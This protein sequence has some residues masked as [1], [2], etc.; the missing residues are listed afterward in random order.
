M[1]QP[2]ASA[3]RIGPF[4]F[5]PGW[6]RLNAAT[7]WAASLFTIGTVAFMSFVQPY[8]LNEMVHLPKDQ[9]GSVTG[10]LGAIQEIVI[11]SLAGFVGAWSDRIGRRRV[12]C[13]G[14]LLVAAGYVIFPFA[15]N[16]TEL[17][18]YR[19]VFALGVTLAPLMLSACVV[20]AIEENS[21]GR[22]IGS[23]NLLQGLG[24][25]LMSLLLAKTPEWYAR[26]GADAVAAGR[27]AYWTAA[28]VA[29]LAAAVVAAGLPR[30]VPDRERGLRT[31]MRAQVSQAMRFA[32]VS[33]RLAL[34]YGAAFIGRGDF[35]V[36]G[37]FFS[38]WIVQTGLERGMGSGP[39]L[40]RAG[41]LFGL[42][43]GAAMMWA[44]FM[45]TII[46]R[47]NRVTGLCV[48]LTL[49]A[50]SYLL[51]G[52]VEDPFARSFV[53]IAIFVGIGE[54]S[55]IVASGAL[56]GQ[57]ARSEHRGPIVGFYNAVGGIGILFAT[58]VGG[59]VFDRIGGTAPFTMMG[60][61]NALLLVA[62]LW[63]RLKAG[64]SDARVPLTGAQ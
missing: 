32:L 58:F 15:T 4:R 31:T 11:I 18:V 2:E 5:S 8:V 19:L 13:L 56:L 49:A 55:V 64:A 29:L 22:W 59:L 34:A 44:F 33:P 21:R 12:Y 30:T 38:L 25:V 51:L 45:G 53:P 37:Y 3:A 63:T 62:A 14:F 1:P 35:T 39:S 61:L 6:S 54:V 48:A 46:D 52:D 28:G 40:A 20:D 27:Y 10:M 47:V 42:V 36:I 23:N 43:Q 16:V 60:A 9:Q 50:T 57:E 7:V 41:M 24:V 17:I 26:L